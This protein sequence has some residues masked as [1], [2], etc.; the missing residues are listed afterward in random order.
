MI[1]YKVKNETGPTVHQVNYPISKKEVYR[2][3]NLLEIKSFED[4][5]NEKLE[6]L[7]IVKDSS[8]CIIGVAF[9]DGATLDW[10]ICCG[11]NNYY[12]EVVF[13]RPDGEL[14]EFD[15]TYELDD[16]EIDAGSDV[17]IINLE[18]KDE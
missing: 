9:N 17:Y 7:G 6:K 8:E 10:K 1:K 16:I 2:V 12:D 14:E 15:C 18:L 13:Q 4:Y 5:S 3:R 11:D